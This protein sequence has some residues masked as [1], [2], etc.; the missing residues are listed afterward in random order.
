MHVADSRTDLDLASAGHAL[1]SDVDP[2]LHG[3]HAWDLDVGRGDGLGPLARTQAGSSSLRLYMSAH[4]TEGYTRH[5]RTQTTLCHVMAQSSLCD[6]VD[7]PGLPCVHMRLMLQ[8]PGL[9]NIRLFPQVSTASVWLLLLEATDQAEP[10]RCSTRMST[11]VG[12]LRGYRG[13]PRPSLP[14][15]RQFIAGY[16]DCAAESGMM[17]GL[18]C[19]DLRW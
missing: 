8:P 12:V 3:C 5:H 16:V 7:N 15:D 17:P 6:D 19:P 1:P 4:G 9:R 14:L 11:D 10:D 2:L 18:T 13:R